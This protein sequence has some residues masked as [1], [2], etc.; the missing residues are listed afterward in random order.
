MSVVE[1]VV[2]TV[3]FQIPTLLRMERVTFWRSSL[4]IDSVTLRAGGAK[5]ES[6]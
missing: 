4:R 5:M 1:T 3:A 6:D 2:L